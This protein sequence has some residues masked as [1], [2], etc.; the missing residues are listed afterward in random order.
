MY[1]NIFLTC[2]RPINSTW[3]FHVLGS[4]TGKYNAS[5]DLL[6]ITL[7]L[8]YTIYAGHYLRIVSSCDN[9]QD[10]KQIHLKACFSG[11]TVNATFINECFIRAR[12]QHSSF[13]YTISPI[14]IK[15]EGETT[16]AHAQNTAVTSAQG[17]HRVS[18]VRYLTFL[19]K[20]CSAY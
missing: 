16:M 17:Y 11:F 9:I 15:V 5:F 13:N 3:N 18:S 19:V 2:V 14:R 12:C 20:N 8:N 10:T 4:M 6:E 1:S 7:N